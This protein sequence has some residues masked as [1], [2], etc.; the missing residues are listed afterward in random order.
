MS[1][2][3]GL[4]VGY[5]VFEGVFPTV[6]FPA[7]G[8]ASF[9]LA[10]AVLGLVA[11]A[12]GFATDDLTLGGI[13]LIVSLPLGAV[14]ASLIALSPILFSGLYLAQPGDIPFFVAHYGL[15]FFVLAFVMNLVGILVGMGVRGWY[16]HR[17]WKDLPF[18][19]TSRK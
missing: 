10:L 12:V 19:A 14:F 7:L 8:S 17:V 3:L 13:A 18:G 2:V 4:S 9:A 5:V 16:F 1:V 11:A 15:I 6:S